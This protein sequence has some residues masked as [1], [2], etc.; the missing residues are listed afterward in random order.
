ML[1]PMLSS[2]GLEGVLAEGD[3]REGRTVRGP[4]L[5][6]RG[7]RDLFDHLDVN[8]DGTISVT[9]AMDTV[10]DNAALQARLLARA[11][12]GRLASWPL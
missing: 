9:E 7:L 1:I 5:V 2:L 8:G 4:A 10:K 6:L 11:L 12:A 3:S